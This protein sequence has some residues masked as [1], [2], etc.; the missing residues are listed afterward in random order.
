MTFL[1]FYALINVLHKWTIQLL[2]YLFLCNSY[3][4]KYLLQM[5]EKKNGK[6]FTYTYTY[7]NAAN[8]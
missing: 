4:T 6:V 2:G 1:R 5:Q 3:Y 8:M 7:T